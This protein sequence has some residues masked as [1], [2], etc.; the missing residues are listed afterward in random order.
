MDDIATLKNWLEQMY[1]FL[2]MAN[3]PYPANFLQDLPANPVKVF[4]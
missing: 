2:G 3:Y 4:N 1:G